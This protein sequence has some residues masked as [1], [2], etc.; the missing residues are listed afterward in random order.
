MTLT[1]S[2]DLTELMSHINR[3]MYEASAVNRYA[4]FFFGIF[5]PGAADSITLMPAT[6]RPCC[7]AN[8]RLEATSASVWIVAA[9]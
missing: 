6:I 7:C 5:D 2:G 4:T 8:Y 1:N 3:L 9:P